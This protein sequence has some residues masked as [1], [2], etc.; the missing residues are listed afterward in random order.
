MAIEW[1]NLSLGARIIV[2]AFCAACVSMVMTWTD[3]GFASRNGL[4]KGAWLLFVLWIYPVAAVLRDR[5]MYRILGCVCAI[6]SLF[7]TSMYI[8]GSDAEF[9]GRQFN[10]AGAGAW[11]FLLASC[12]LLIGAIGYAPSSIS[13]VD[14]KPIAASPADPLVA[15]QGVAA[16]NERDERTRMLFGGGIVLVPLLVI[17]AIGMSTQP[18]G[19]SSQPTAISD[20]QHSTRARLS[21]N[22]FEHEI[23]EVGTARSVGGW[24]IE[25]TASDGGLFVTVRW[26]YRNT[27]NA[28]LSAFDRPRITLIAPSGVS[29][30]HDI[31]ASSSYAAEVGTNEKILSEINPLIWVNAAAVFEVSSS[32]F[33]PN[34]WSIALADEK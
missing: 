33:D 1:N 15:S 11:M 12:A 21:P 25:A 20:P 31:N 18:R 8:H 9:F 27:T 7:A 4:D 19:E 26:R 24:P 3:I 5:P 30:E 16:N 29:Y 2:V 13:V 28:P 22:R 14:N 17:V 23:M 6:L 34:T 10:S 32:L